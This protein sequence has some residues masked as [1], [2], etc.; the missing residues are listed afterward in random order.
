MPNTSVS[1][2][3]PFS[4]LDLRAALGMFA[5]GVT[6]VT[7][8]NEGGHAVGLTANSFTSV[9][10]APPLVLWSL[11]ERSLSMPAFA[12]AT[13]F[14]VNVLA[15]EQRVIAE[16][17]ASKAEDRFDG[18]NW[19]I[20][21]SGVPVIDGAAAVFECRSC[22]RHVEGDH[23]IFL[24]E[25]EHCSRRMGSAPLVFWGGRFFIDLPF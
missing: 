9:S 25:V 6:V 2:T 15:A 8:L 1:S 11:S 21:S 20:G 4:S 14:A 10:L 3:A 19:R 17:F 13:H 12:S 22:N 7:T 23:V 24:G 18:V 16:R 5:T